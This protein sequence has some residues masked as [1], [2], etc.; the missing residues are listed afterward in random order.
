[1]ELNSDHYISHILR[2]QLVTT[3]LE[4]IERY[5]F[6]SIACQ[7]AILVL[8]FLKK[9]MEAD[10]LDMLK[11][12]VQINLADEETIHLRFDSGRTTTKANLAPII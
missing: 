9:A 5:P 10:E 2:K 8:D 11:D 3:T 4:I 6:C 1:V 7:Q 12:F